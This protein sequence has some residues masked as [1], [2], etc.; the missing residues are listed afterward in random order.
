MDILGPTEAKIAGLKEPILD[1]LNKD[2]SDA[3]K[4]PKDK[5]TNK[6]NYSGNDAAPGA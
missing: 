4:I 1:V 3:I 2:K 6:V 5:T